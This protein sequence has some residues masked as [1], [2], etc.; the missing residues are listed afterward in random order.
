[1]IDFTALSAALLAWVATVLPGIPK[2][3]G[4]GEGNMQIPA[5]VRI[6]VDEPS[7]ISN[8]GQDEQRWSAAPITGAPVCTVY[9]QRELQITIRAR[10]RTHT[11]TPAQA[12]ILKLRSS[13]KMPSVLDALHA[14]GIAVI[15]TGPTQNYNAPFDNRVES[16]AAFVVT[17]G[18]GIADTDAVSAGQIDTAG[19][20]SALQGSN[21]V[22]LP[23]PPNFDN[24]IIGPVP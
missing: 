22:T 6:E 14:A 12:V 24:E 10:G 18:M 4:D 11:A 20:S 17:F 19:L 5:P 2:V 13:L 1:M 16:I 23:S 7:V 8:I 21:G 9:G 3:W 15:R